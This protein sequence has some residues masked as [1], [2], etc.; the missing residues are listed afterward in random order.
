MTV[1]PNE[2]Q[3]LIFSN[4]I[5]FSLK[6]TIWGNRMTSSFL[7]TLAYKMETIITGAL[8]ISHKRIKGDTCKSVPV[9]VN[10]L[11]ENKT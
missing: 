2:F 8:S 4:S 10:D 1:R 3:N 9:N 11:N 5:G 6:L 7:R